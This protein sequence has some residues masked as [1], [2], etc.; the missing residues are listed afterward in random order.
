MSKYIEGHGASLKKS[1]ETEREKNLHHLR[2]YGRGTADSPSWTVQHH[3]TEEDS[4][5]A[6]HN[7]DNGHAMLAH[8]AEHAGVPEEGE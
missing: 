8:V 4:N 6:E 5:P 3:S 1:R 2:I 7:F